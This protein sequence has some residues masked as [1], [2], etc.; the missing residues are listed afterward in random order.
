MWG[1][2]GIV[3]HAP[4]WAARALQKRALANDTSSRSESQPALLEADMALLAENDVVEQLD[5]QQLASLAQLLSR[6]DVLRRGGRVARGMVVHDEDRGAG[7]RDGWLVDLGYAHDAGVDRALI[8][9]MLADD[10]VLGVQT[11]HA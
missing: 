8:D 1:Y 9:G 3:A 2:G 10:A 6:A 4:S 5:I 11:E 7:A